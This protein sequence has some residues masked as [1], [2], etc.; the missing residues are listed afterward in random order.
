MRSLSTIVHKTQ[1]SSWK[2]G[3]LFVHKGQRVIV[4][5]FVNISA[6]KWKQ[7]I[8]LFVGHWYTSTRKFNFCILVCMF[9]CKSASMLLDAAPLLFACCKFIIILFRGNM[10]IIHFQLFAAQVYMSPTIYVYEA[11][12]RRCRHML[13]M[14]EFAELKNTAIREAELGYDKQFIMFLNGGSAQCT[15]NPSSREF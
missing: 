7:I 15:R 4:C 2:C 10:L 14:N 12:V 1:L 8:F 13:N 3:T 9:Y 6:P 11:R 5:L